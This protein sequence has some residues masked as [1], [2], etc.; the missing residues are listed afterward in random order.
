MTDT[1]LRC[2]PWGRGIGAK[3]RVRVSHREDGRAVVIFTE[4]PDNPGM[5][6]TNAAEW[7]ATMLLHRYDLDLE[8]TIWIEHYPDRHPPGQEGDWMFDETIALV[9]FQWEYGRSPMR[10]S[11]WARAPN[12]K[13]LTREEIERDLVGR[14]LFG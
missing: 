7:I 5:S 13:H 3:C 9:E 12:W 6:V 4:L 1:I 10:L 2:Q 11:P 14:R 8:N